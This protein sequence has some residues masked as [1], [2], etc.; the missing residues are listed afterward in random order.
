MRQ[1]IFIIVLAAGL[2]WPAAAQRT[3]ERLLDAPATG[4]VEI[5]NLSGSVKVRGW[6]RAQVEVRGSLDRGVED[7]E[8]TSRGSRTE[9]EVR[10]RHSSFGGDAELEIKVPR[11][12]R[13]RIEVVNADVDVADVDG[14]LELE[15]V[16][17][18]VRV[19][20]RPASVRAETVSGDVD[21]R[22]DSDEVAAHTVS[23]T[24]TLAGSIR[25][26][27]A[28]S[29]SGR[30]SLDDVTGVERATLSVVSGSIRFAGGLAG[31]ARFEASSHNGSIELRLP[32][33]TSARIQATTY[34]G[35]IFNELGPAASRSDRHGP[36]EELDFTLGSGSARID[37]ETFNGSITLR[38][39]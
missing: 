26:V 1:R 22:V 17:G 18:G 15:G 24:I 34:N 2:A 11:A 13:V 19:D 36:Q 28:E 3:F 9:I 5:K 8:V 29:V 21:V 23:G 6:D 27:D 25:D 16:N 4:A 31:E 32:A 33:S 14:D 37:L 39:R 10:T 38:E 30:L 35:R 12:S 20:G 7:I